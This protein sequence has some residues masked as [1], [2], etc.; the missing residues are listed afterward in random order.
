MAVSVAVFVFVSVLVTA[1]AAAAVAAPAVDEFVD[2]AVE[3][4][5]SVAAVV[6]ASV[7]PWLECCLVLYCLQARQ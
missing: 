7:P 3:F 6:A 2:A 1:V 4:V 5:E